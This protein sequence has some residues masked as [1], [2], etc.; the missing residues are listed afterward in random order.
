MN[1]VFN[2]TKSNLLALPTPKKG[3]CYYRDVQ[4]KGLSLYITSTGVITFFVRKRIH[5]KDERIIL[6]RF[7]ELSI[8]NARKKALIAKAEVAA[9][10]NPN[11]ERQKLRS[12]STF[13]QLFEKYIEEHAKLH[14]KSWQQD[15]ASVN[16]SLGHWFNRKISSISQ[17]EVRKFHAHFGNTKGKAG[18]NRLLD[19]ISAIYNKAIHWGW[20]GK[21]PAKGVTKFKLQS[22]ERYVL[23]HE[24][25]Y[26]FSALS[27][28]YNETVRDFI[29]MA[30][31]TGVRK[32][33]LLSMQWAEVDWQQQQWRIPET[34]NGDA[35]TIPLTKQ[36][37]ELLSARRE[38]VSGQWVFPSNR[39]DDHMKDPKKA[40]Y[41]IKLSATLK[42]WNDLPDIQSFLNAAEA[43]LKGEYN[44]K[45]LYEL[46]LE[47]AEKQHVDLPIGLL[48]LR[49]HDLRRTLGS[50]LAA[51]NASPYIISKTLGHKNIKS[52]EPYT[53]LNL[54]PVRQSVQ[55][56]MDAAYG[57]SRK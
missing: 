21:N 32:G 26:L 23:P 28:T 18:A 1:K 6:G 31:N 19:R 17:E 57:I 22:R 10:V 4:E 52:G 24:L 54:D 46:T 5:G 37:I 55:G 8:L 7:P 11:E 44:E 29:L 51:S 16:R 3:R 15:V 20:D 13:K 27:E 47:L 53:R 48:D 36:A 14:T 49:L 2:F 50:Y 43:V 33:N 38:F 25:S 30:L 39:I 40:W 45:K 42:L 41:S 9:G 35:L 12:D 34:K 56:V